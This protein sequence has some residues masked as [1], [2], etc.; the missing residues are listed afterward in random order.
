AFDAPVGV[1]FTVRRGQ[2]AVTL[3]N[4]SVLSLIGG[5]NLALAAGRLYTFMCVN[6]ST[7]ECQQIS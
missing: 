1:P 5:A 4:S 7:G 6:A 3:V 2:G